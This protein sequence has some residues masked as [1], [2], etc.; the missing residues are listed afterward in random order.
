MVLRSLPPSTYSIRVEASGFRSEVQSGIVLEV[1]QNLT[2]NVSLQVGATRETVE[3]S[4]Q[5]P[6]LATEDAVT[7]QSLNRTFIND[8]PLVGRSVFDLALLTPGSTNL[9]R[10]RSGPTLWPITGSPTAAAMRKR[11]S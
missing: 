2:L 10:T 5:P 11:T 7:G 4:A 9:P 1:N 8:L 6:A 3:V